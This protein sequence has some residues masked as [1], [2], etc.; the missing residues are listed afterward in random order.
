MR[1][2]T[3]RIAALADAAIGLLAEE[4]ARGLTH[5]AVDARAAMPAGTTSAYLRTRQA[6]I[7][8]VVDRLADL[9]GEPAPPAPAD[10]LDGL[11]AGIAAMLDHQLSEGRTRTLARYACLLEATYRPELR[12]IL[13]HGAASRAAARQMLAAAG[14][15][16]A[17]RRGDYLVAYLDGLV[18]DRLIGAGALTAPPPGTAQSKADLTEAVRLALSAAM[19]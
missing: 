10:D 15:A 4:G 11:A 1:D 2:R 14:A 19:R 17:A 9:D 18:F 3:A 12:T 6:L 13:A 5:R 7:E 16:D 8:A